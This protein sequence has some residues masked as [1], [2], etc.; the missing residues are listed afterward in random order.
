MSYHSVKP[1]AAFLRRHG[2]ELIDIQRNDVQGGSIVG[3]AQRL[4]GTRPVSPNVGEIIALETARQLDQ[5]A[6]L[7][8]FAHRLQRLKEDLARLTAQPGKTFWGFGAARSGTTLIAQ[9]NLGKVI[10]AIVDDNP[11]KQGKF[12]PGDHIPILPTAALYQNRPDYAFLLAWVHAERIIANH[13]DY[14][15]QG[16]RFIQCLPQLQLIGPS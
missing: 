6:P 16:G 9:M 5:P 4:G 2:L 1:L 3:T 12:S 13:Q 11:A 7:R 8:Q 10:A 14:L 15:R